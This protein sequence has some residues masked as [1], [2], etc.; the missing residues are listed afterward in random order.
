MDNL[1]LYITKSGEGATIQA[2]DKAFNCYAPMGTMEKARAFCQ[3]KAEEWLNSNLLNFAKFSQEE[4]KF[5]ADKW[6]NVIKL[7][8]GRYDY[9]F[10]TESK[11]EIFL[12]QVQELASGL[13]IDEAEVFEAL[14]DEFEID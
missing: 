6:L 12:L 9:Y 10:N 13:G 7:P 2:N 5:F 14:E 3:E 11:E 4:R 8:F 1:F